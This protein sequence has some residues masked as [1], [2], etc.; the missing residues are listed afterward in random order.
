MHRVVDDTVVEEISLEC[1][2]C[3]SNN[4]KEVSQ[5]ENCDYTCDTMSDMTKGVCSNIGIHVTDIR[6]MIDNIK[7]ITL[8]NNNGSNSNTND[9]SDS[10]SN[11]RYS[12]AYFASPDQ[13]AV[14]YWPLSPHISNHTHKS[15][16]DNYTI[17]TNDTAGLVANYIVSHDKNDNTANLPLSKNT[18]TTATDVKAEALTDTSSIPHYGAPTYTEW[19]KKRI[20]RAIAS[21]KGRPNK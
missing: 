17:T 13:N 2:E 7:D 16:T 8:D 11:G 9:N 20:A 1:I 21:L 5:S 14:M 19:R 4:V 6:T 12:I 15:D 3:V 10:N 18:A